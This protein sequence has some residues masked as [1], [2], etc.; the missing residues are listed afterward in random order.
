MSGDETASV[1]AGASESAQLRQEYSAFQQVKAIRHPFLLSLERVELI[2]GELIMVM[3]LADQQLGDRFAECRSAG[4]PGIP[5]D[6]LVGYLR[7]AAEALDVISAKYGL[8]HLDVKPANLFVTAGHVK[9]GDYGL[10]SRLDGK[11]GTD[12]PGLTPRYAAPEVLRGQIHTRSDQYSLALVY[13]ELLTGAFPYSGRNVQ[14]MMM[15]HLSAAP[16][17][18]ALPEADRGP[19]AMAM[20]KQPESRFESCASFIRALTSRAACGRSARRAAPVG[21]GVNSATGQPRVRTARRGGTHARPRQFGRNDPSGRIV[22]QHTQPAA[23]HDPHSAAGAA[24]RS[25]AR[26]GRTDGEPPPVTQRGPTPLR[27]I[28]SFRSRG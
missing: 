9:V 22:V 24:R 12:N 6:E 4:L 26:A 3:E 15:Q 7:E 2:D 16:D 1:I 11:K 19:V 25:H 20:A 10:V 8:Q 27:S 21:I 14:A 23:A 28:R 17:L 18:S 5:R 13:F